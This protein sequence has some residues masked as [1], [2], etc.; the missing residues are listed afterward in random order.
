MAFLDFGLFKVMPKRPDRVRARP[1]ARRARAGRRRAQAHLGGRASCRTPRASARTSIL[2]Q[3]LDVTWWY[4]LDEEIELDARDRDPG[5]DRDVRPALAA[6]RADAPRDA[7]RRPP[8]R[9]PPRDAHA[10]RAVASCAR[11]ATGTASRA[12]G[13]TT[14]SRSPSSAARRPSS[15]P[16][17]AP[18]LSAADVPPGR[19]CARAAGIAGAVRP[20]A[21]VEE[22]TA[23]AGAALDLAEARAATGSTATA[24]RCRGRH[25]AVR[26]A[27]RRALPGRCWRAPAGCC[28]APRWAPL[29]IIAATL[30]AA[31]AFLLSRWWAHDA[32]LPW[33][34]AGLAS[35]TGSGD[36]SC[37]VALR[38]LAPGVPY[39]LVNYAAGLTPIA[40]RTFAAAT[41]GR[42][43]ARSPTRRWA[44]AWTTSARRRSSRGLLVAMAISGLV[45]LRLRR[46]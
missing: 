9:P 10:R 22:A 30:G 45:P 6:L 31:L 27:D 28:S 36:A 3:F 44:A 15:T 1:P 37:P 18:C 40:L 2:A 33:P 34:A 19:S 11:A 38:R 8:L 35:A 23:G 21:S 13:S 20:N 39:H 16:R 17:A 4:T 24:R 7:A 12:S 46:L 29:S 42:L 41:A 25:L 26:A 43:P 32:V 14:T 5:D